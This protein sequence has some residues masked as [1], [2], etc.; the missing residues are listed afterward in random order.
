MSKWTEESSLRCTPPSPR[1]WPGQRPYSSSSSNGSRRRPPPGP[2]GSIRTRRRSSRRLRPRPRRA[3]AARAKATKQKLL[4]A[5]RQ[6]PG[7]TVVELARAAGG[8]RSAVGERLRQLARDGAIVKGE[9]GHWQL[10]GEETGRRR[11]ECRTKVIDRRGMAGHVLMEA[12]SF[13]CS[14]IG[15]QTLSATSIARFTMG[16]TGSSSPGVRCQ[17]VASYCSIRSR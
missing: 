14:R 9:G 15:R 8:G 1:R 3:A 5:L 10:R 13:F 11:P 16:S 7:L 2:T 4:R 6:T 12:A 17:M